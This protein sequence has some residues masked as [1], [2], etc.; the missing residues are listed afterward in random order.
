[1]ENKFHLGPQNDPESSRHQKTVEKL[2]RWK[3]YFE[4][5]E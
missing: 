2:P 1:M 5:V 3:L 4:L